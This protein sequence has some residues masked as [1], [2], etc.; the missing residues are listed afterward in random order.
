M[1]T[2]FPALSFS[3]TPVGG[4][5]QSKGSNIRQISMSRDETILLIAN[6]EEVFITCSNKVDPEELGLKDGGAVFFVHDLELCSWRER[7][8]DFDF[9]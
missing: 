2:E 6:G 1:D 3:N 7:T 8:K 5:S 4:S 9:I